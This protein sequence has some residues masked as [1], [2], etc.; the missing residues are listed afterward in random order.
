VGFLVRTAP[1]ATTALLLLP[2]VIGAEQLEY[3]VSSNAS[4]N[5]GDFVGENSVSG[6]I[7]PFVRLSDPE[8]EATWSLRYQPSYEYYLEESERSGFDHDVAGAFSWR[9]AE[10][11]TFSLQENYVVNQSVIRFNEAA[12]P[13]G[14]VAVGFQDQEVR[15]NRTSA[16]LSHALTPR[17]N[18]ALTL[19]YNTFQYPDG[20]QRDRSSPST[21]LSYNHVLSERTSAGLR[22]SWIQQAQSGDVA[23]DDETFFYNLSGTLEHSFSRTFRIEASAGPTL[24]DSSPPTE[25]EPLQF[26][27]S[28]QTIDLGGVI[29][30]PFT[31]DADQCELDGVPRRARNFNT[32][33]VFSGAQ[34]I[35]QDELETLA[36]LT[37]K[38][39]TI[40]EDGRPLDS[41]DAS[42]TDLTY[43]AS[44]ALVKDWE[45]WTGSLNYQRSNSDSAQFGSSSVADSF[46]ARLTWRPDQLWTLNLSAGLSLYEQA[47]DQVVPI[48]FQLENVAAPAGVTSVTQLAQVQSLI[49]SNSDDA[50]DYQTQSVSFTA[51]RRL[52]RRA[53][54]F[55]SVYW[56][57]Q[58]QDLASLDGGTTR[59][60]D[61]LR[62]S[63]GLYWNFD[64]IRF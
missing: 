19:N 56:S 32:D 5:E 4:W 48:A 34:D 35:T 2:R 43:F 7:S 21:A 31:F 45:Y 50:R 10:R 64:P 60:G 41:S 55:A 30:G 17:D 22:F 63:V 29:V 59:R 20:G 16:V 58:E 6:R 24:V 1:I 47:S 33:C 54:A 23:E 40:D 61:T 15:S 18:L 37:A 57:S 46:W 39:P 53:S 27:I 11:W 25:F 9:F 44:L 28:S 49:L 42:G 12:P 3:G 38:V 62:L 26:A 13:G 51:T 52:G 8:G 36:K 14:E